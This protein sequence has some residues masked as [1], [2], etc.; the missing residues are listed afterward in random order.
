MGSASGKG[1]GF[2]AV[3]IALDV[4]AF[5]G[6]AFAATAL[7]WGGGDSWRGT[8]ST[9]VITV[10]AAGLGGATVPPGSGTTPDEGAGACGAASNTLNSGTSVRRS[11]H[12]KAMPGR[13][14]PVAPK[15]RLKSRT[16]NASES[17]A[18]TA[19]FRRS[20]LAVCG[21]QGAAVASGV[22]KRIPPYL[23][24]QRRWPDL[25]KAPWRHS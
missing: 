12:G 9:S 15:V 3:A 17:A 13:P 22:L 24:V 14:N 16:W 18:P 5:L 21:G 4:A 23:P 20:G 1:V 10:G 25:A 6:L 8:G 2:S 11:C 7:N 19:R